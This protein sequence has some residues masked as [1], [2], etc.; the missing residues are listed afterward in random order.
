MAIENCFFKLEKQIPEINE[1]IIN[2]L[3]CNDFEIK[4]SYTP[5]GM[6]VDGFLI[7]GAVV[8]IYDLPPDQISIQGNPKD[9]KSARESLEKIFGVKLGLRLYKK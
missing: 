3:Y 6:I 5:Q 1:H 2:E 8:G 4:Y 7:G 9:I